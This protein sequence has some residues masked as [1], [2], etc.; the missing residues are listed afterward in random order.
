MSIKTDELKPRK[1]KTVA[2][3]DSEKSLKE[4][5]L[6]A[7]IILSL[8]HGYQRITRDGVAAEAGCAMGSVNSHFGTLAQLQ[9][10]VIS[11]AIARKNLNILAQA[12]AANHPKALN[13]PQELRIAAA[14]SIIGG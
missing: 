9:R 13:A 14:S 1:A 4:R 11:A 2:S 5:I 6:D 12:L 7:A 3:V 10:A 8:K